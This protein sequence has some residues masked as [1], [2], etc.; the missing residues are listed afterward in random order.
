MNKKKRIMSINMNDF[1]GKNEHLMNHRYFNNR[2]RKYQID[3]KY[4]AKQVKKDETWNSL[5]EY[6]LDKQPDL[7][8]IE[9]MLISCYE[10]ID[11]IGEL[12]EIG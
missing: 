8:V 7:L 6:I 11:F 10:S 2:D 12:E 3:W 5:K 1:G 4:W 9:E